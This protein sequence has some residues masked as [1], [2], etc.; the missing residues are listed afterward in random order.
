MEAVALAKSVNVTVV[1]IQLKALIVAVDPERLAR[2]VVVAVKEQA[3][4][5]VVEG[6]HVIAKENA[7]VT[8]AAVRAVAANVV[9]VPA[10]IAVVKHKGIVAAAAG[11][12][13]TAKKD[14]NVLTVVAQAVLEKFNCESAYSLILSHFVYW[15][16]T[17][18][19]NYYNHK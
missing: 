19:F 10:S 4:A 13:V 11:K 8:V 16:C 6:K 1:A 18:S 5:A 7:N 2:A 17:S 12:R 15:T 14:V 9:T 3:K